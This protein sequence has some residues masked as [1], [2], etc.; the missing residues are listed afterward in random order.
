LNGNA[1]NP[2]AAF[3]FLTVLESAAHG[4]FG[5][6]LVLSSQGRPLEF[7]CST[8]V[9]PTRAQ[10]I[11]Y[12]PTLRPYLLSE[13]IGKSL[14]DSAEIPVAA[15]L[16]NDRDLLPLAALRPED[17]YYVA[18]LAAG[19]GEVAARTPNIH[20]VDRWLIENY[21]GVL[22]TAEQLQAQLDPLAAHVDLC[23]PFERILAAL[24]EAQLSS[25]DAEDPR[26]DRAAA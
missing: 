2:L 4:I 1:T 8:P 17:V 24:A 6:Y 23:E 14:L 5:G 15:T 19:Q 22:R 11:L 12:G 3:G 16:T 7:R 21:S 20:A 18:P 25:L 10:Q 26:D 9:V 13:I